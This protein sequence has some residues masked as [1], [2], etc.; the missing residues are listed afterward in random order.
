MES[1]VRKRSRTN[2][3]LADGEDVPGGI[4]GPQADEEW[5]SHSRDVLLRLQ[6][7]AAVTRSAKSAAVAA[8]ARVSSGSVSASPMEDTLAA[9]GAA[10]R[11]L[12]ASEHDPWVLLS[13]R[14]AT[15][16]PLLGPARDP[17][18][19]DPDT[20]LVRDEDEHAA[21]VAAWARADAG[22]V[23]LPSDP[24]WA[25]RKTLRW[26]GVHEGPDLPD[27]FDLRAAE[28]AEA[29]EFL[30][31]QEVERAERAAA[32]A[33][34]A[35]AADAAARRRAASQYDRRADVRSPPSLLPTPSHA[36]ARA[37]DYGADRTPYRDD[38]RRHDPQPL[39]S[40]DDER[41]SAYDDDRR[42]PDAHSDR[43][44]PPERRDSYDRRAY[45]DERRPREDERR[46]SD[47]YAHDRRTNDDDRER[48]GNHRSSGAYNPYDDDREHGRD[49]WRGEGHDR[50][51]GTGDR[52]DRRDE[53]DRGR[54]GR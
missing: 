44:A 25:F 13:R 30:N 11:G 16:C 53:G 17:R 31:A 1:S 43:R 34:A 36:H 10:L 15:L 49:R 46:R 8:S 41:R 4:V 28:D 29:R 35:E 45:D 26:W 6:N 2:D 52:W 47:S 12:D 24:R 33:A 18:F 21:I 9:A 48:R 27:D 39:R 14:V 42:R 7:L 32:A 50:E 20:G 19:I 38:G 3:V 23:V 37:S 40:R 51:R 22:S 54:W 5:E